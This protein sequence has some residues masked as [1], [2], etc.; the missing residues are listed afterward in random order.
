[1]GSSRHF[2]RH[3]V[4]YILL[5]FKKVGFRRPRGPF[6][7]SMGARWGRNGKTNW[8]SWRALA[9]ASGDT[10]FAIFCFVL[11]K[12]FFRGVGV[13]GTLRE[14]VPGSRVRPKQGRKLKFLTGF[15]SCLHWHPICYILL[16][17]EKVGFLR[18]LGP[19]GGVTGGR[20]RLKRKKSQILNGIEQTLL[21]CCIWMVEII[22]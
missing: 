7:R 17:L 18:S 9:D 20:V 1:M 8:N 22:F 11:K 16:H 10:R 3:P 21:I 15:S 12:S 6:D 2:R 19:F 13:P 14:G 5:H 4:S